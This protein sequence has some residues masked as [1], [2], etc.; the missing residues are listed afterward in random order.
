MTSQSRHVPYE[1]LDG[2]VKACR[3]VCYD[4]RVC[5]RYVL[6][7]PNEVIQEHFELFETPQLRPRFNVAPTDRMPVVRLRAKDEGRRLDRF[8][9]GLLPVK[10]LRTTCDPVFIICAWARQ[11]RCR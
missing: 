10:R 11:P 5:G 4:P 3:R 6:T 8:R 1:D 7:K 2:G 9:W